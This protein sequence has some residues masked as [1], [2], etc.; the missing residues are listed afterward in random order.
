MPRQQPGQDG[1]H[2]AV[3]PVRH[4]ADDLPMQHRDLVPEY[5]DLDV[6]SGIAPRQ[7][8]QPAEHPDHGQVDKTDHHERRA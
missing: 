6:L 2:G 4:R 1:N 5:Q 7:E 3:S 8:H